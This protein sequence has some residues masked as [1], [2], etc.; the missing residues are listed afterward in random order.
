MRIGPSARALVRL[1]VVLLVVGAAAGVWEWLALQSPGSTWHVGALP[2]PVGT[3][4]GTAFTLGLAMIAAAWL[5]P[6][7]APGREPR[8]W[9]IAV[10]LGVVVVLIALVWGATTGM[11]G[12]QIEDLRAESKWLF[13][14]RALGTLILI[15]CLLDF[16]RR[17]LFRAPP[18]PS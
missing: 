12:V 4:R 7:A 15:G 3:L 8:A 17:I 1:G 18:P 2:G 13:R 14:L 9:V 6:W 11:Y 10:H 16:A 5:M